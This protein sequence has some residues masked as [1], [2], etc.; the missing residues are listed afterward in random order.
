MKSRLEKLLAAARAH[1]DTEDPVAAP[2]GLGRGLARL[3][4]APSAPETGWLHGLSIGFAC[5]ALAAV[6]TTMLPH[7][8]RAS[9]VPELYMLAGVTESDDPDQP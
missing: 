9:V 4:A 6:F 1:R 8:E 7:R 5:C 2:P 3:A